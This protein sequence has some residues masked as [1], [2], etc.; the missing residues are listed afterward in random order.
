MSGKLSLLNLLV[1]LMLECSEIYIRIM[2]LCWHYWPPMAGTVSRQEKALAQERAAKT[3]NGSEEVGVTGSPKMFLSLRPRRTETKENDVD[4]GD[5]VL[6]D[7]HPCQ[8]KD[9]HCMVPHICSN[10]LLNHCLRGVVNIERDM[11]HVFSWASWLLGHAAGTHWASQKNWVEA[12]RRIVGRE[13]RSRKP[14]DVW[15]PVGYREPWKHISYIPINPHGGSTEP[16]FPVDVPSDPL[17]ARDPL[18]RLRSSKVRRIR[19]EF[20]H[21]KGTSG[22]LHVTYDMGTVNFDVNQN[23]KATHVF[24]DCLRLEEICLVMPSCCLKLQ[25]WS[26]FFWGGSNHK[27]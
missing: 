23:L 21:G 15:F 11:I 18:S 24:K 13:D 20:F 7:S 17:T 22:T 25:L 12:N 19:R 8:I 9:P 4:D 3:G 27:I 26:F 14:R 10:P 1:G 6:S 5:G 16:W 2:L